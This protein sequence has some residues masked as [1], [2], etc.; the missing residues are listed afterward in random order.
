LVITAKEVQSRTPC[1][2]KIYQD[3]E[4][5]GLAHVEWNTHSSILKSPIPN[6]L[7]LQFGGFGYLSETN[8]P[9]LIFDKM[10]PMKGLYY[11]ES[12]APA[13]RDLLDLC[14]FNDTRH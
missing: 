11:G 4:E 1:V 9:V 7:Q 12:C 3:E 14:P 8:T 13:D 5:F 2:L 10:L 6:L